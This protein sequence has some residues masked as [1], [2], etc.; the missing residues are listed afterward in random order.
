MLDIRD[1]INREQEGLNEE[2][3][4]ADERRRINKERRESVTLNKNLNKPEDQYEALQ[5]LQTE[6][7]I[8][9]ARSF[10]NH[11]EETNIYDGVEDSDILEKFY[12]DRTWGNYNTLSMGADV[13]F[14]A[15]EEDESR[16]QQFAYL[17]QTFERLPSFW[18]DPNRSFG[19]WLLDAGGAMVVDPVNLVGLGVGKIAAKESFSQVL[20]AQLKGKMAKEIELDILEGIA[21]ES[22]KKALGKAVKKGAVYEG[23]I[24]GAITGAQDGLLQST[25]INTGVQENYDLSQMGLNAA[26]GGAFGTL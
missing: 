24:A 22:S 3:E 23:L 4:T 9:T 8:E 26:A 10:Y 20:K 7:F 19:R 21:K 17:Q 12:D 18:N 13:A 1:R 16:I 25:A 11:R 14:T 6:K 15:M 2:A 5:E